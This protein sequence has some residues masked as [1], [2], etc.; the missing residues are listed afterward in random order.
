M[1][2]AHEF[3]GGMRMRAGFRFPGR[4]YKIDGRVSTELSVEDEQED[5]I[6]NEDRH[7]S[8]T[9]A[10]SHCQIV[11]QCSARRQECSPVK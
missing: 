4:F 5:S 11:F 8:Q 6:C 9:S 1:R 2:V 10:L 7:L 3:S